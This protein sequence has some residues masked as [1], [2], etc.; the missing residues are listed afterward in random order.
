MKGAVINTIVIIPARYDSTRFPGKPLADLNG[1]PMLWHVVSRAVLAKRP[2]QVIVATED[3]RIMDAV[4]SWGYNVTLTSSKHL[5]GSDR[6]AEVSASQNAQGRLPS[7]LVVN[8]QG[9]L[10]LFLPDVLDRLI[11]EGGEWISAGL[12]DVVTL[13][14]KIDSEEEIFSPHTVKL[15]RDGAGRVLYFSR[16]PI[17]YV[18]KGDSIIGSTTFFKHYGVYL[19]DRN[20]LLKMGKAPEGKLEK[21]ERLEQLRFLEEGGRMRVVEISSE[22]AKYFCEVNLPEDL[23]KANAML[24]SERK[25]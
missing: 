25:G 11:E 8:L 9:D 22:E 19:Y 18:E 23:L 16:S 24:L 14:A 1:R 21:V 12:A 17:P 4:R 5:T 15:V 20:F 2:D 10:P 7:G 13:A 6:V 3:Q